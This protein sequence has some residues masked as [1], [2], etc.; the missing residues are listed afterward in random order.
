MMPGHPPHPSQLPPHPMHG[1]PQMQ[2]PPQQPPS[3]APQSAQNQQSSNRQSSAL[4]NIQ[5]KILNSVENFHSFC[6]RCRNQ[7]TH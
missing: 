4:V 3:S 5:R 7:I 1:A 6:S 2:Q